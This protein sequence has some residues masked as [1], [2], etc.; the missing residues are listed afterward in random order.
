MS[1]ALNHSLKAVRNDDTLF[2][3]YFSF[4]KKILISTLAVVTV[5]LLSSCDMPGQKDEKKTDS[6]KM[7]MDNAMMKKD[8]TTS[9][10]MMQA[11]VK[12][13]GGAMIEK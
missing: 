2:I 3:F 12:V 10:G 11:D 9:D 4:M 5:V 8:D 13:E 1:T 7:P 6:M